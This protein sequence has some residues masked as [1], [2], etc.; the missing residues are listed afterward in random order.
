MYENE[1]SVE[2]GEGK[3]KKKGIWLRRRGGT[4][5]IGQQESTSESAFGGLQTK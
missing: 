5:V 1:Y 3:E 2:D 4:Q